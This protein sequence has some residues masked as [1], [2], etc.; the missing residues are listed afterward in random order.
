MSIRTPSS[1][2]KSAQNLRDI[3]ELDL[4]KFNELM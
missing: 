1:P 2:S 3:V 4:D